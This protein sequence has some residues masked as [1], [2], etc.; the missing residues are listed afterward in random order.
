MGG[1]GNAPAGAGRIYLWEAGSACGTSSE[2]ESAM[3]RAAPYLAPGA[4]GLVEEADLVMVPAG[5]AGSVPE[6]RRTGRAWLGC[7]RGGAVLWEVRAAGPG[8]PGGGA[9][10]RAVA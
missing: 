8:S 9:P 3:E 1:G 6:H 5:P 10:V 2:R 4:D 7:V